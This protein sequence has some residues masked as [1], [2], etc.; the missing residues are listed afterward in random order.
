MRSETQVLQKT[1]LIRLVE[2]QDIK[3]LA[4]VHVDCWCETYRGIVPEEYLH[5]LKYRDRQAMWEKLLPRRVR[6]GAT[7]VV[8]GEEDDVV[9]FADCGPAREHEHGISG[10]LYAI[11][12]LKRYQG[13]GL[14]LELFES[15]KR[16]FAKLGHDSFYLWVLRDNPTKRFYEKVGGKYLKSQPVDIGGVELIE[17]LYYWELEKHI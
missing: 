17:D 3:S 12:L 16:S 5:S 4:R 2:Q 1:S 15:I 7:Y 6:S 14:G 11:Y 8:I 9:G 10:E 13:R